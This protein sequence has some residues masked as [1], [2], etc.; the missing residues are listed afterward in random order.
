MK[1]EA[2]VEKK[3]EKTS[4]TAFLRDFSK[5]VKVSLMTLQ[6]VAR[7]GRVVLYYKAQSISDAT[8]GEVTIPE[9]C[10]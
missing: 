8:G 1:F 6:H 9:L 4:R 10:E 2:W 7:G 3:R 5:E